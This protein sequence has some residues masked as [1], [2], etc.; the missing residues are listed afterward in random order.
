MSTLTLLEIVQAA[1]TE[2]GLLPPT[3]VVGNSAPQTMQLYALVNRS[4]R[5]LQQDY[6]WTFL[7]KLF[8]VEVAA[9]TVTT[10]DTT[11][12]SA[13]LTN[14]ASTAGISADTYVCSGN[15]VP[16]AARVVSVDSPTQVTL[17][18]EC[19]GDSVATTLTFAK[20]TYD[21][22]PDFDRFINQTQWDRTNRWQLLGPDS[23]QIDE[24]HRSG[25][26][27]VGPRRHFRQVGPQPSA[28]RF[29]PPPAVLDSPFELASEYTSANWAE[30]VLGVGKSSMT[31]DDDISLIDG[32]AIILGVKWRYFQIKQFDYAPLQQEYIDYCNRRFGQDGGSQILSLNNRMN[33]YLL[34]SGNIQ[35]GF[36]PGRDGLDS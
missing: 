1:S 11:S 30:S 2:L 15:D 24:W 25:I 5:E 14:L 12:G 13:I 29:W 8:I 33:P 32:N 27:T 9:P 34:N 36:F 35:D 21:F 4:G 28:L 31:A 26:V 3:T 22:P 18:S 6:E 19:T 23:P 7:Q 10:G 20:D 17:D 16:V